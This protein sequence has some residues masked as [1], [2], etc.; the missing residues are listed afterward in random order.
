MECLELNQICAWA[1]ERGLQC[2]DG[3]EVRL[4]ELPSRHWCAYADGRR[5][6][7]ERA[8]AD[9]FIAALGRWE[10]CLVWVRLW[11]AWPSGENWPQFYAWRGAQDEPRSLEIAPGH[12]F[13]RDEVDKL[14]DLLTSIMENAWD[15]EVLCS[16]HGRADG[17]RGKISHD[18]WC[19]VSALQDAG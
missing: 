8:A 9:E 2:S 7:H 11:G 18:E 1:Q 6:G 14:A 17:V 5:T 15:A 13:V 12:R 19:E 3:F 10:E 4:P 16:R